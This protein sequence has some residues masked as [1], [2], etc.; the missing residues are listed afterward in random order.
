MSTQTQVANKTRL[1][2]NSMGDMERHFMD[3]I[4]ERL[5][6]QEEAKKT[7]LRAFKAYTNP[8]R[9][10][11]RPIF[12][13][14]A[15]GPS[16]TGKTYLAELLAEFFH[17]QK[18]AMIKV[19]CGQYQA[20]HQI[21]NLIGAPHGYIG[22]SD[23]DK[24]KKDDSTRDNSAKLAQ[25]NLDLARH[26]SKSKV[27][28]LLFDE[29][30]KAHPSL[31]QL[32]LNGFDKGVID[33]NNNSQTSLVNAIIIL[34]SNL[35]MGE[36][37]RQSKSIGFTSTKPVVTKDDV[38]HVVTKVM[39][40]SF[41]PEFRNRID[42]V[43]I[44]EPMTADLMLSVVDKEINI[45]NKRILDSN[46]SAIFVVKATTAA[47]E[48]LLAMAL[49]NDGNLANLKRVIQNEVL[50]PL[51]DLIKTG[52]I[53]MGDRIEVDFDAESNQLVFDKLAFDMIVGTAVIDSNAATTGDTPVKPT[54]T[55]LVP[56]G[57]YAIHG[58]VIFLP[59]RKPVTIA[60]AGVNG[61]ILNMSELT[62]LERAY[63]L[64][65]RARQFGDKLLAKYVVSFE[66]E[67]SMSA[68]EDQWLPVV[69]D[70]REVMEVEVLESKTSYTKP[71]RVEIT[72]KAIPGQIRLLELRFPGIKIT[73]DEDVTLDDK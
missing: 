29:F 56:Y 24:P 15:I 64:R 1:S 16:R 34:T 4:N 66:S 18:D 6:G 61:V 44:Y 9:D 69:T 36:V 46:A 59:T 25:V 22:Y 54:G 14:L 8:L 67:V 40:D 31:Q 48:H 55:S 45:I 20:S 30:E 52:K 32:L 33:L 68:V 7:A 62:F 51:G 21:Q 57:S 41:A 13:M 70:L 27:D 42:A 28:V 12:V 71:Y 2:V 26:G 72:I 5:V 65:M 50:E 43:V 23:A 49:E 53:S 58:N 63:D 60:S 73:S 11:T 17:G 37:E 10:R 47:K 39:K 3:F 19:Q 35:G 38:S